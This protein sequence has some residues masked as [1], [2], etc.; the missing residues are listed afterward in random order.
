MNDN[1]IDSTHST[2]AYDQTQNTREAE[3]RRLDELMSGP[4]LIAPD[5]RFAPAEDD[6]LRPEDSF[7]VTPA[8]PDQ[9][10]TAPVAAP[11]VGSKVVHQAEDVSLAIDGRGAAVALQEYLYELL[12][13]GQSGEFKA[14]AD[15]LGVRDT[16]SFAETVKQGFALQTFNQV[17]SSRLIFTDHNGNEVSSD[18]LAQIAKPQLLIQPSAAAPEVSDEAQV[19]AFLENHEVNVEGASFDSSGNLTLGNGA[20]VSSGAV[21]QIVNGN[22]RAQEFAI[23]LGVITAGQQNLAN[24]KLDGLGDSLSIK[25]NNGENSITLEHT[26][27]Q[28]INTGNEVGQ[29]LSQTAL[30]IGRPAVSD[31]SVVKPVD[32]AVD[33]APDAH[34]DPR[35]ARPDTI[36]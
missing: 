16:E 32:P 18:N 21:D 33:D 10:I 9:K 13:T 15:A 3:R 27:I 7:E 30:T 6:G 2:V 1:R 20:T 36:V 17:D 35:A 26:D 31:D 12:N 8:A 11:E 34:S 24:L 25:A 14:A 29:Q 5:E 22:P 19:L 28:A 23:A 4:G